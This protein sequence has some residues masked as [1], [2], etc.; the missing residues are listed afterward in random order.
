MSWSQRRGWPGARGRRPGAAAS[1]AAR[2]WTRVEWFLDDRFGGCPAGG[3]APGHRSWRST[4][5]DSMS[6]PGVAGADRLVRAWTATGG[7]RPLTSRCSSAPS[8]PPVGSA[9]TGHTGERAD[10]APGRPRTAAGAGVGRDRGRTDGGAGQRRRGGRSG[11]GGDRGGRARGRGGLL[12]GEHAGA[13]R[14]GRARGDQRD[15]Q[16]DWRAACASGRA[17]CPATSALPA[18]ATVGLHSRQAR[19]PGPR[20]TA[21]AS[22]NAALTA[23]VGRL[24]FDVTSGADAGAVGGR[25]GG[26]GR[27]AGL[28]AADGPLHRP[29]VDP[30]SLNGSA[31]VTDGGSRGR[32]WWRGV[33][34][35]FVAGTRCSAWPW[36]LSTEAF[37]VGRQRLIRLRLAQ[38]L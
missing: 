24:R 9:A 32:R 21:M 14:R 26:L 30:M 17:S 16:W 5:G 11:I 12:P 29:P 2:R 8:G 22:W 20:S 18:S 3:R 23:C 33:Q 4:G 37:A 13:R 31:S 19:G 10:Q 1:R 28:G 15:L 25:D 36:A 35:W 38:G 27:P 6:L 34:A 7:I